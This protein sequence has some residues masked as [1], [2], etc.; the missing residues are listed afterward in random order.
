MKGFS[1]KRN[2]ESRW[3]IGP[4][5]ILFLR[6]ACASF[7]P[8]MLHAEAVKGL[9]ICLLLRIMN[10]GCVVLFLGDVCQL[11]ELCLYL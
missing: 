1:S 5:N 8:E 11:D 7:S 10:T 3:V 4:E 6:C 9:I 2:K